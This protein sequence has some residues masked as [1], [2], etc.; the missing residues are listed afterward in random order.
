M[1]YYC[2]SYHSIKNNGVLRF[3]DKVRLQLDIR[4][5]GGKWQAN[6]ICIKLT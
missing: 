4:H 5:W 1:M 3:S 6:F 2:V